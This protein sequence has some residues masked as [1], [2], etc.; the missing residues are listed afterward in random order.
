MGKGILRLSEVLEEKNTTLTSP[1]LSSLKTCSSE[2]FLSTHT[3][4]GELSLGMSQSGFIVWAESTNDI[5]GEGTLFPGEYALFPEEK[6]YISRAVDKRIKEYT[7]VRVLA[8]RALAHLNI[9]PEAILYGEKRSPLWPQGISGAITH[10]RSFRGL[11][12]IHI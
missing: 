10:C 5:G 1:T 7:T 9:K 3:V 4:N 8:R 2:S 6:T 11:S 12:L